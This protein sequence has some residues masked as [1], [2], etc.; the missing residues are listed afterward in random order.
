[1]QV[2]EYTYSAWGEILSITGSMADSIGQKNPLRYRGYYYDDESG[3][4]YLL[5]RYYDAVSCRFL[6]EDEYVSTGQGVLGFNM[7]T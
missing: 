3:F 5:T 6:N 1:M 4:Y 2:V 7:F